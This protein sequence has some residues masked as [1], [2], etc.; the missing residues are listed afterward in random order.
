MKRTLSFIAWRVW[1]IA[2]TATILNCSIQFLNEQ[3]NA[4][5]TRQ[6][7]PVRFRII[8][9]RKDPAGAFAILALHGPTFP[10]RGNPYILIGHLV[11]L[12]SF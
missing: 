5:L 7:A 8:F 9:D 10:M 6:I 1:I 3:F 4:I 2:I 11:H 12:L